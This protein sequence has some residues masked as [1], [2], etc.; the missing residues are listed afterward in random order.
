MILLAA[1]I[2]VLY[3][4]ESTRGSGSPG[5]QL[6]QEYARRPSPPRYTS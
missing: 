4:Q 2:R 6:Y 1:S 3:L 5:L